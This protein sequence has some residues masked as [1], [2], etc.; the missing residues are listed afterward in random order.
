MSTDCKKAT[1]PI[2]EKQIGATT[3][4]VTGTFS[5]SATETAEAKMRRLVLRDAEKLKAS[6]RGGG[7]HRR[8]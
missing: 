2:L 4:R 1:G 5:A 8:S 7:T 3:Y 6:G